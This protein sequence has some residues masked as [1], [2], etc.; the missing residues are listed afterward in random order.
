MLVTQLWYLYCHQDNVL[1]AQFTTTNY[2]KNYLQ[3]EQFILTHKTNH[4]ITYKTALAKIFYR[5]NFRN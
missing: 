4:D 3:A 2:L 5:K 1:T